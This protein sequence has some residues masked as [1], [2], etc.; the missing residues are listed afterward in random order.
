MSL[1]L[2]NPWIGLRAWWDEARKSEPR[3]HDAMQL[4]TVGP[5]GMPHVRTV[6]LKAFSEDAG[7]VFFTHYDS[8]KGRDLVAHPHAAV[9]LHWK[10]LERQ[11]L[12]EGPVKRLQP[13]SSD[14]YWKTRSRRSRIGALVSQQSRPMADRSE[15]VRAVS[16]AESHFPS[17]DV[18]R[19]ATWGGYRIDP[20][21]IELWQ[22]REDRLH[23]R[24]E[25]RREG[26]GWTRRWLWP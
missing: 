7:L 19:P 2:D 10:S 17:D 9:V 14:A 1:D 12:A 8:R 23:E 11:V 13:E 26:D 16:E 22:G 21:R 20:V 4:A 3:V 15:L 25:F 6:L 5:D 18:P 24:L